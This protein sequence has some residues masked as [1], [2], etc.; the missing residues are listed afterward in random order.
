MH[1]QARFCGSWNVAVRSC[2]EPDDSPR[3]VSVYHDL[4]YD[5]A[6]DRNCVCTLVDICVTSIHHIMKINLS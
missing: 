5:V 1:S 3:R 4:P 6:P 2:E